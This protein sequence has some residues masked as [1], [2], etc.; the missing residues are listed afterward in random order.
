MATAPEVKKDVFVVHS[1]SDRLHEAI[2]NRLSASAGE[3]GIALYDY[4]DWQWET[5]GAPRYECYGTD[6]DELDPVLAHVGDPY[7][8]R[9]K[10]WKP[11]ATALSQLWFDSRVVLILEA[12]EKPSNGMLPE[13][14]FLEGFYSSRQPNPPVMV[15]VD[16]PQGGRPVS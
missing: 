10:T 12:E 8:F 11:D 3:L 4:G 14:N 1:R 5:E 9:H 6:K 7:P 2:Y 16:F 15:S 13:M